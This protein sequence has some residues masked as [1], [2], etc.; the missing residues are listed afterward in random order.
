MGAVYH[1]NLKRYI[2][3]LQRLELPLCE[4]RLSFSFRRLVFPPYLDLSTGSAAAGL[5]SASEVG[6]IDR[7]IRTR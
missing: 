1:E 5:K 2:G 7:V 4:N 3:P 6:K